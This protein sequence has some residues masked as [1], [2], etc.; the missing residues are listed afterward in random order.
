VRLHRLELTAFGPFAGSEV[1]DFEEL[2]RCG[3]YLIHGP[4]G[5][6]KTSI[7]DAVC[8]ALYSAVPGARAGGRNGLRSDHAPADAVPSVRLEFTAAGRRFRVTRSPEFTRPKKRGT[9]TTGVPA[10]VALQELLDGAWVERGTRHQDVALVVQDV[11]GMGLEQFV[12]VVLL[13]QGE[14]AAFLRANPEERHTVLERL[15]D[16]SRFTDIEAWLAQRK[17]TAQSSLADLRRALETDL[18]RVDDILAE[19]PAEALGDGPGDGERRPAWTELA[20]DE[21]GPALESVVADVAALSA[22]ALSGAEASRGRRDQAAE[23]LARGR[24]V[25]ERQ[26]EATKAQALLDALDADHA[27][28]DEALRQVELAEHAAAVSGHLSA[29]NR[30]EAELARRL[31]SLT[32]ARAELDPALD[33][34][35]AGRLQGAQHEDLAPRARALR[36]SVRSHSD[37]LA[38]AVAAQ[39]R[40]DAHAEQLAAHEQAA[41]QHRTTA[42]ALEEDETAAG[43]ELRCAEREVERLRGQASLATGRAAAEERLHRAR[44]LREGRAQSDVL[45]RRLEGE[46]AECTREVVAAEREVVRLRQGRLEDMAGELADGLADGAA[47]PVCGSCEHPEPATRTLAVTAADI[48]LAESVS[49]AALAARERVRTRLVT[50]QATGAA[51]AEELR[52]ALGDT[53]PEELDEALER[54]RAELAACKDAADALSA[55]ESRLEGLRERVQ[56]CRR[57]AQAS[58]EAEV[59]ALA[60]ARSG[61][62]HVV[63]ER[64]RLARLIHAHR[65]CPCAADDDDLPS[66]VAVHQGAEAA[67]SRLVEALDAHTAAQLAAD[68]CGSDLCASLSA[69]GFA[70]AAAARAAARTDEQLTELKALVR[71]VTRRRDAAQATLA[72]PEVREAMGLSAPDLP[73]LAASHTERQQECTRAEQLQ[74]LAER[75]DHRLRAL[76]T[77]IRS[78]LCALGPAEAEHALVEGLADCLTGN[79]GDNTLKMRLSSYVLAARLEE[80][81][82]LA[83]ERLATMSDGRY[84]LQYSDHRAARGARSGLGLLVTDAWTGVARETSSLSGGEA[85][86][87]SLALALGLGD[88]VRAEAGGL[89]L[90]TLF[91]DEGF[92]TLD[93]DSLEQVMTV[94]DDLREGGRSVGVVSH[95]AELRQRITGQV[96]VTKTPLGS[97]TRVVTGG[98]LD[99]PGRVA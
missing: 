17:R 65:D 10:K 18:L 36:E 57:A 13:P 53:A 63:S 5:A 52:V 44:T 71:E 32:E 51:R 81:A 25:Q 30:A 20:T 55:L 99:E 86:M 70:D 24:S 26:C 38:Q 80:V 69:H 59:S 56:S 89:D 48:D 87:A 15:F 29:V 91:V 11:I 78:A 39:A 98:S 27:R 4:T 34:A 76:G 54:A 73:A 22:R 45:V 21:L 58:R 23:A 92:G 41:A 43:E 68:A 74:A 94:L 50:E 12:K 85:F 67:L 28:Y 40:V 49:A 64:Q 97:T 96:R 79:G 95:V 93:E 9:G 84:A 66:V 46:L 42:A 2:A 16:T 19:L 75:S 77:G 1:I 82:R 14:F 6:G 88:A 35:V 3:L 8:F 37:A 62:E 61:R 7:L 47:C 90:Q 83:N 60:S 31:G 33:A 72:T